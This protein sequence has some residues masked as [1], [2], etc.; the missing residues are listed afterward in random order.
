[1]NIAKISVN[2]PTLVVVIFT[3]LL[4]LG[5]AGYKS[6]KYELMPPMTAPAFIVTVNYPGA[7]PSEVENDL[8]KKM[9]EI[10]SSIENIEHIQSTS[11]EGMAVIGVSMKM[12]AN[13]DNAIQDAQRRINAARNTL[14][15]GIFEPV[16]SK[17]AMGDLPVIKIGVTANLSSTEFYDLLK[18]TI[19]PELSRINGVAE[20][21][22]SGG[23]EREIKVS[24][25]PDKLKYNNLSSEQVLQAIQMSN[26]DVPV[27]K[28]KNKESEISIRLSGKFK[29]I[30]DIQNV[31]VSSDE[32]ETKVLLK[33]VAEV[34]DV[35]KESTVLNRTNGINSIGINIRKQT[36]ANAVEVCQ[37][38]TDKI[39]ELEKEYEADKLK[40]NVAFNSSDFTEKAADSVIH[41]LVFAVIL[42]ALVMVV[43]L[44]GLRNAFIVMVAIPLSI[45]SSFI[46]MYLL[47]Y[48]LN[49]MTLLAMSLVIGIL[50]D[51]AIVVLENIYRH[52]EMGKNRVQATLDGRSEISFTAIAITLVDVVVFLPIGLSTGF[53]SSLIAPFAL[54][55]V[56]TTLL[57]LFV[58][59]TAIPLL[60]SR[61]AK[62]EHLS[63]TK[64][65]GRLF[66]WVENEINKFSNF[67]QKLLLKAM[68]HK[69][70]SFIA[71]I[72]MFIASVMLIP[73]GFV[74]TE[75]FG[76]GDAGECVIQIE[77]PK[78]AT[79]K[80][81]NLKTLEIERILKSKP[82]IKSL[83][84]TIG[85]T[86]SG[87]RMRAGSTNL[88]EIDVKLVDKKFRNV[89]S[90][91][92]ANQ[93]K[94]ELRTKVIG[95]KITAAV[96]N[97]LFGSTDD[98]P[99][100]IIV[101]SSNPDSLA[102]YSALIQQLV[103]KTTGTSDIK[104]SLDN[105]SN[106]ISVDLDKKKMAD[107]GLN[108]TT[109]G[110]VMST[111]FSGNTDTKFADGS[112]EYDINVV[113]DEFNRRN[114]DDV[115]GLTFVNSANQ[116]I[117]LS[118][119]ATIGYKKGYSIL[120]Q[121]DKNSSI[122]IQSQVLGRP[123]GDVGDEIKEKIEAIKLPSD[124]SIHYAGDME[125][126]ADGFGTLGFALLTAIF[127]VY[128]IMVA[129]YESYLYPFVVLS[130]IPLAI[131]GAIL[132]LAL[133]KQTL[134]MFSMVGMIM[135]IGLVAKNAILIVDFTNHLKKQ[136]KST[137][138]AL[139]E[140]T[141]V[142][143]RP[144]LM[145]TS[146][147]IIGLLPIALA[148]GA[149]SEWKNGIAWVLIGGLTSSMFLTLIIVPV[150]FLT[151]ESMK[152]RISSWINKILRKNKQQIDTDIA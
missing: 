13:I 85:A 95:A 58:A 28:V 83:F 37:T 84:T 118:Q 126:Q 132:G 29:N 142:R 97:P 105:E 133:A 69:I 21:S 128:L 38:I 15:K 121:Y 79:L 145:T 115:A 92:Y 14:P 47:G 107:L 61:F 98:S 57:S 66:L 51:D 125:M 149:A 129:L 48:S 78:D 93:I 33:D 88:A 50:V 148:S 131:I 71:V 43:F 87:M 12:S 74:G 8:T 23:N 68:H 103:K 17:I 81:T 141:K 77:M 90:G 144:V 25:N 55:V 137:V 135:L 20:V 42:V 9:E 112:Y 139:V 19:Q 6:L 143:L 65:T 102:K 2:R 26:M 99:I 46:G 116:Q 70:I 72:V 4:F 3:V 56:I 151:M 22:L 119:F 82:E 30:G 32:N 5:F 7:S 35:E 136:G 73:A 96:M 76:L 100:Q 122:T 138:E 64:L 91:L 49:I 124:V 104:S 44:H 89:S 94:N 24:L 67:I 86:S 127:L 150:V 45:I 52:M 16:I 59:F 130:T 18:H 117:K 109:V 53:I 60:A 111:A 110:S 152:T 123:S 54:V 134:N 113:F 34:L 10:I 11:Y 108:M 41:D 101:K 62:L 120:E 114:L 80:E 31:V 39:A 75:A 140:A 147:M 40:F 63:Q 146:A 106:E 27:G 36:D 1:M